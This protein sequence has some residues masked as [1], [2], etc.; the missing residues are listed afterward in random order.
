MH[1]AYRMVRVSRGTMHHFPKDLIT[2]ERCTVN[3]SIY[4]FATKK[5]KKEQKI[6][7]FAHYH[8]IIIKKYCAVLPY[9]LPS[10]LL[11]LC[12]LFHNARTVA[13]QLSETLS[14]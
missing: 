3:A 5:K 14:K 8:N 13:H 1:L 4:L 7:A 11:L 9:L 10:L 12:A 2:V 6:T